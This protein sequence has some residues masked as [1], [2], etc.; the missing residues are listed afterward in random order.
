[1]KNPSLRRG[2]LEGPNYLSVIQGSCWHCSGTGVC[3]CTAC[4]EKKVCVACEGKRE[5]LN[6]AII[7]YGEL[8]WIGVTEILTHKDGSFPL[9]VTYI[10]REE[11]QP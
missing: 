4:Y 2:G 10:L 5:E 8:R 1:M 6:R 11:V 9:E 7:Q 3:D